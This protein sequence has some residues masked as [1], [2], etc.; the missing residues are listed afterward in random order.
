MFFDIWRMLVDVFNRLYKLSA[1]RTSLAQ[2]MSRAQLVIQQ[3]YIV[4]SNFVSHSQAFIVANNIALTDSDLVSKLNNFVQ[5]A[6]PEILSDPMFGLAFI[7]SYE[8]LHVFEFYTPALRDQL[9]E[10]AMDTLKEYIRT[11]NYSDAVNTIESIKSNLSNIT[12]NIYPATLFELVA[13]TSVSGTVIKYTI[14]QFVCTAWQLIV[15]F[16]VAPIALLQWILTKLKLE[17]VAIILA[18]I[19][20]IVLYMPSWITDLLLQQVYGTNVYNYLWSCRADPVSTFY[21]HLEP[22]QLESLKLLSITYFDEYAV[23]VPIV[24]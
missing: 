13:N 9:G 1:H 8:N 10:H 12:H 2:L 6:V 23:G 24:N 14:I 20:A 11:G 3:R 7:P 19:M 16:L 5:V 21:T 17:I 4:Y 15:A 18:Y 22:D